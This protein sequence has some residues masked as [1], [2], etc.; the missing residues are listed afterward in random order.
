M[1]IRG[2]ETGQT[3]RDALELLVR[4]PWCAF[5]HGLS[6]DSREMLRIT[7]GIRSHSTSELLDFLRQ[8]A[9]L[10]VDVLLDLIQS[11]E[12]TLA[13]RSLVNKINPRSMLSES[14]HFSVTS[15][16]SSSSY[17]TPLEGSRM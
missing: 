17:C 3:A 16:I 9:H 7:V 12:K 14:R 13:L 6:D 8:R 5:G 4:W 15:S 11:C 2:H 1:A 10:G